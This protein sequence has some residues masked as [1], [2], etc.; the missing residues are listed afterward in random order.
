MYLFILANLTSRH[1]R[2]DERVS[3]FPRIP[4]QSWL[5]QGRAGFPWYWSLVYLYQ[6]DTP[7]TNNQMGKSFVY[8]SIY[9]NGN[10][11]E[12]FL[13]AQKV[14]LN[15][16][17]KLNFSWI[18]EYIY[19]NANWQTLHNIKKIAGERL[20]WEVDADNCHSGQFGAC[21]E[22]RAR[23]SIRIYCYWLDKMLTAQIG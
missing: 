9:H 6:V 21:C 14:C 3:R 4:C 15:I 23:Y 5:H 13:L 1:F 11:V 12:F 20:G 16:I 18:L 22:L 10:C 8:L 19:Y 7:V 2:S 17:A